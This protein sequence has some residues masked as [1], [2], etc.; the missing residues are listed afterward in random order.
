M[1]T[2]LVLVMQGM[3]FLNQ[4]LAFRKLHRKHLS[5]RQRRQLGHLAAKMQHFL[6]VS[7][8]LGVVPHLDDESILD[9]E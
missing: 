3:S 5:D 4:W 8:D 6:Q 1:N 2:A 9:V 7:A